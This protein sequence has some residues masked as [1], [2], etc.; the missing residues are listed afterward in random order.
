VSAA[1][2]RRG[3][4]GAR[5]ARRALVAQVA[6]RVDQHLLL[7]AA[8]GVALDVRP[9]LVVPAL[10]ALLA[11]AP[12]EVLG[13]GA[14]VALAMLADQPARRHVSELG[15][16]P[17]ETHTRPAE[18]ARTPASLQRLLAS[19]VPGG[20]GRPKH[21]TSRSSS[22]APQQPLTRATGCRL[23]FLAV[24]DVSSSATLASMAGRAQGRPARPEH[25]VDRSQALAGGRQHTH[26]HA[27]K[28]PTAV[29]ARCV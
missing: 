7:G 15:A 9:Q 6:V 3:A 27:L 17:P 26:S 23:F 25:P 28:Q 10:T 1:R 24:L 2:G 5:S 18:P 22:S 12:G 19:Q 29:S 4:A 21:L 20:P 8:P 13:Y 14:P 16:N 11:D